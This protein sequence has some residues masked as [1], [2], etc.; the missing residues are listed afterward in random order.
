MQATGIVALL[1]AIL[2]LVFIGT[3]ASPEDYSIPKIIELLSR[4]YQEQIA[5]ETKWENTG[6]LDLIESVR[7]AYILR[8]IDALEELLDILKGDYRL[9]QSSK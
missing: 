4:L 9:W 7:Y 1:T 3:P 6:C 2:A 5:L 8:D